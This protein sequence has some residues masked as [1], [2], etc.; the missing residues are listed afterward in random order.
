MNPLE[1]LGALNGE[2][3]EGLSNLF[4]GMSGGGSGNS[5]GGEANPYEVE[6]QGAPSTGT[7]RAYL[8]C[9]SEASTPVDLQRCTAL[10][11]QVAPAREASCEGPR[12]ARGPF[13]FRIRLRF[14]AQLA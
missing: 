4:G 14:D 6:P 8:K 9:V 12:R 10:S 1:L 11:E 3:G 5:G 7:Q 13:A 2:G